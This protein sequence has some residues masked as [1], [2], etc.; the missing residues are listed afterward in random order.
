VSAFPVRGRGAPTDRDAP[1]L[2]QQPA[3]PSERRARWEVR[4]AQWRARELAE[5]AFGE[6]SRSSLLGLRVD[7]GLRGLLHLEVPWSGPEQHG[8]REARFL[9]A[10]QRDPILS[11]VRL[12]YVIGPTPR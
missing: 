4:A 12:V 9:E 11:N 1:R 3:A 8:V 6:V 10:T 7:G 2:T 5:A